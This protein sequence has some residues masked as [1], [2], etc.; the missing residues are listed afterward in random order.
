M[1]QGVKKSIYALA[2]NPSG[3]L[4]ACGSTESM[5]RV[6]D[7][8]TGQKVMKLKGHTDNVRWVFV[9]RFVM[10]LGVRV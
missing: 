5:V 4:L 8:R 3:T 10:C 9:S 7:A 6:M 1:L 2:M